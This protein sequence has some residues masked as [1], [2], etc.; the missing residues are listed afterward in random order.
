MLNK[1]S[2]ITSVFLPEEGGSPIAVFNRCVSLVKIG[3]Q[4]QLFI[5]NYGSKSD[6]NI[7]TS[8]KDLG[9]V[10]ILENPDKLST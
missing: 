5:P 6:S 4:V 9:V 8:L 1:I 2:I 3:F 10:L 7:L